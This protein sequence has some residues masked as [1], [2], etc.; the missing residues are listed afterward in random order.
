M[1]FGLLGLDNLGCSDTVA[2]GNG[3]EIKKSKFCGSGFFKRDR[4][5][6]EEDFRESKFSQTT[7]CGEEML[8]VPLQI[9]GN[10]NFIEGQQM[11]S[12]S[13]SN[14]Q[15]VAF[16][17]F[18]HTSS[19]FTRNTGYGS[20]GMTGASLHGVLSG[21]R[22]PFTPS[23]W[24]EL[25]HQALI[26]KYILAN[27]P[28][29]SYLLNPIRKALES[30]GFSAFSGL[31]SDAVG[32]GAFY[33]GF[34][35]TD[36]EPGRCR[37]TDG[38]KWRCS[39]D[40]VTDQKY[41]ERHMNRG[42]HRSRKPVEGQSGHSASGI[43]NTIV[44]PTP[45]TSSAS[46]SVV[47]AGGVSNS[48]S[49]SHRQLNYQQDD[50]SDANRSLP[51][52]DNVGGVYQHTILSMASSGK[53]PQEN[54]YSISKQLRAYDC[55]SYNRE[56]GLVNCDSLI[57]PVSKSSTDDRQHSFR[58]LMDEWPKNKSAESDPHPDTTQ[59][60]I[61]IP[62]TFL[63]QSSSTTEK[64]ETSP[65]T[66][67]TQHQGFEKNHWTPLSWEPS[68]GGPLGEVLHNTNNTT[69]DKALNLMEGCDNS[70]QLTSSPTGV[71]QR[72]S[73]SNSSTLSSPR[74]E[75]VMINLF[76]K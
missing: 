67:S 11:L 24:M 33:L 10:C 3:A 6:N 45:I 38:K 20:V 46:A 36:P 1:D 43:T 41:C 72:G 55:E 56:F 61:S 74:A 69:M 49:L 53:G 52:M 15:N 29:P 9:S 23:Q 31:R 12:F 75:T 13:S 7:S 51:N 2:S 28:I 32:W 5:L 59:L 30:A 25:E 8:K 37:R 76:Q 58:Q 66:L 42:R 17:Y 34:P 48:L 64:L 4:A 60:S 63:P 44:K 40:A 47:P 18:Q 62:I 39:R 65:T 22:S 54:Q 68:V 27:V 71:L 26:Y 57:N 21:V 70:S 50:V 14:S 73:L 16:P 35:N 19:S